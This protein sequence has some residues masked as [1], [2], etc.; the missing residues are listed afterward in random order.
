VLVRYLREHGVEAAPLATPYGD[1]EV[2]EAQAEAAEQ[3]D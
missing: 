3:G 1:E 2:D